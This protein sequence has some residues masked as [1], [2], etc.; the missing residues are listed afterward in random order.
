MTNA[1]SKGTKRGA[2]TARREVTKRG[3]VADASTDEIDGPPEVDANAVVSEAKSSKSNSQSRPSHG[4]S[5]SQGIRQTLAIWEMSSKP[6]E[7]L[8]LNKCFTNFMEV[9]SSQGRERFKRFAKKV[10]EYQITRYLYLIT[11]DS[12]YLMWITM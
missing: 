7:S 3:K 4:P 1:A 2:L 8:I 10:C 11:R 9:E 12:V 6:T 5:F